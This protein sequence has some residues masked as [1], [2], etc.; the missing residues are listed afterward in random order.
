MKKILIVGII[1]LL[2]IPMLAIWAFI[3]WGS[4]WTTEYTSRSPDGLREIRVQSR[5]CFADCVL[6]ITAHQG[7]SDAI[8]TQRADCSFQIGQVTWVD[9]TAVI[10]VPDGICGNFHL[11]YDFGARRQVDPKPFEEALRSD[12][13]QTYAVTPQE[14]FPCNGDVLRWMNYHEGCTQGYRALDEFRRRHPR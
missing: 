8:L 12:V 14:L 2:S 5:A 11:A 4:F 3:L 13:S 6:R 10:H 1:T 9:S 7:G